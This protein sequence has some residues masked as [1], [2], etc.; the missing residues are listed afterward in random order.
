MAAPLPQ[1]QRFKEDFDRTRLAAIRGDSFS[2]PIGA[3]N[4]NFFEGDG[5]DGES[6]NNDRYFSSGSEDGILAQFPLASP[7]SGAMDTAAIDPNNFSYIQQQ[8]RMN[9]GIGAPSLLPDDVADLPDPEFSTEEDPVTFGESLRALEGQ[10]RNAEDLESAQ[11]A[12]GAVRKKMDDAIEQAAEKLKAM[13]KEKAS[14]WTAKAA[15]NGSNAVDSVGWDAWIVFALTYIYL[16][17][18]GVV[19]LLVPESSNIGDGNA[20]ANMAKKGLHAVLPP[21]RPLREPGDFLYFLFL[22]VI[23]VIII[24]VVIAVLIAVVNLF[25]FPLFMPGGLMGA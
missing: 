13:A 12:G 4:S 9:E 7:L 3:N 6:A 14:R 8:A 24:C 10:A 20:A 15:G 1:E 22:F 5:G 2:V 25:L 18:R 11:A 19:S 21:Y 16:M 23:T 17:A